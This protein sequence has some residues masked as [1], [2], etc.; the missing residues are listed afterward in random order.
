MVEIVDV[1]STISNSSLDRFE[2]TVYALGTRRGND[3]VYCKLYQAIAISP[4]RR[5][6]ASPAAAKR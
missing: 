6:I 1:M 4:A 2:Q 3:H 5:R